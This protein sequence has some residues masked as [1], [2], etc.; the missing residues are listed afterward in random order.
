VPAPCCVS[1]YET[2]ARERLEPGTLGYFA[3]GA[4]DEWTLAE[5]VAAMRRWKLRPRVLVDVSEVSAATTLLGTPVS[6][7]LIVA[8][9]AMQRLVHPDGEV[10]AATAAARAGT[11][12]CLSML[13]TASPLEIAEKAPPG[14]RWLQLYRFRDAGLTRDVMDQAAEA[15]FTAIALT[16]DAPR[17]GNRE[18]DLRTGFRLPEG[19]AIPSL[20]SALGADACP[21]VAELFGMLDMRLTW[22][23]FE[24]LAAESPLPLLVKGIQT[25]ED[26][27]LACEHGAAA[28]VVSNHGGR[29]L[30]GVAATIDL[31]P[32]VVDAV[33]ERL[34]VLMDGGVRRGTDALRALALGADAVL[35]G[36]APLWGLAA[37]GEA[38]ALHVLELLR[39][40][41]ERGLVLLGCRDPAAVTRAHVGR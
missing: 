4:D 14:P 15:G 7:P 38:G 26:A 16:V 22:R 29:Q 18:R 10:A 9:V 2:I 41:I 8:P 3:G 34:P 39:A 40:E 23:D 30:D 11:I 21:T 37:G 31:L 36:R 33:D 5:N 6:M 35:A 27:A 20:V 32:E 19:M 17:A 13:A 28:V 1:D 25:A 12:F 24:E